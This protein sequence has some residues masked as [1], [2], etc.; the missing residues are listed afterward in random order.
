MKPRDDEFIYASNA[1]NAPDKLAGLCT[2]C[3]CGVN[4][5]FEPTPKLRLA[6]RDTHL[7]FNALNT[8]EKS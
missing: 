5:V 6:T 7:I 4:N 2:L 8:W 1:F 3:R